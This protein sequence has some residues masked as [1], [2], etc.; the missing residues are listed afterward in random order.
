MY[1]PNFNEENDQDKIK[2]ANLRY[3]QQRVRGTGF[4]A[5]RTMQGT[6][7]QRSLDKSRVVKIGHGLTSLRGIRSLRPNGST[8]LP[9][10]QHKSP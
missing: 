9:H 4:I 10:S 3:E 1:I 7:E 5:D 8:M 2:L 6:D